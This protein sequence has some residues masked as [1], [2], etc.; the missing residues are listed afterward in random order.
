MAPPITEADVT[1]VHPVERDGRTWWPAAGYNG[2]IIFSAE[3]PLQQPAGGSGEPVAAQFD[4]QFWLWDAGAGQWKHLWSNQGTRH[5]SVI[6]V[7]RDWAL[8]LLYRNNPGDDWTLRL[9]HLQTGETR[10]V[11]SLDPAAT[12]VDSMG[13]STPAIGDGVV[14]YSHKVSARADQLVERLD[15]YDIASSHTTTVVEAPAQ[16][17]PV[18]VNANPSIGAGR[19][20]W[21]RRAPGGAT[22]GS[23][24]GP[25]SG[26]RET[27]PSTG[28]ETWLRLMADGAHV[29]GQSRM[30]ADSTKPRDLYA[31]DLATGET[32]RYLNAVV[33]GVVAYE[34][35]VSWWGAGA[36]ADPRGYYDPSTTWS[37]C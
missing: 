4:Q 10:D 25:A 34:K 23:P 27:V 1:F 21:V 24:S 14:G 3:Q 22:T 33:W 13:A 11:A 17:W 37:T 7:D 2:G 29:I 12:G 9:H 8:S 6:D 15:L 19:L 18:V 28:D 26:K 30:P 32:V 20:A 36:P 35:D 16:G 31:R 5:E